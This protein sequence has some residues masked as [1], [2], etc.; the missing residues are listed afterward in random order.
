MLQPHASLADNQEAL[1]KALQ[2][3]QEMQA[4][5]ETRSPVFKARL[6]EQGVRATSTQASEL[7]YAVEP[8]LT[9]GPMASIASA[10]GAV[11][12]PEPAATAA[13]ADGEEPEDE[14]ELDEDEPLEPA[15]EKVKAALEFPAVA[16]GAALPADSWSDLFTGMKSTFL[17][18]IME[19]EEIDDYEER[20][21]QGMALLEEDGVAAEE[22]TNAMDYFEILVSGAEFRDRFRKWAGAGGSGSILTRTRV[23]LKIMKPTLG[24]LSSSASPW[25]LSAPYVQFRGALEYYMHLGGQLEGGLVTKLRRFGEE[26]LLPDSIA[27]AHS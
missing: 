14:E 24:A 5:N 1:S 6:S 26:L 17:T 16:A 7:Y 11:P 10:M 2:A 12:Q 19:E 21:A 4:N 23:I 27:K 8:R 15:K 3:R 9:G 25:L 13:P 22:I 18:Q 20:L